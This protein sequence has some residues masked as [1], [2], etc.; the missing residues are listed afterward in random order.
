M[1]RLREL[2]GY[3]L[4][5]KANLAVN[6]ICNILNAFLS[7]F[8][9]LS[10]V[11][12][13]RIL[14]GG[15]SADVAVE[16][17]ADAAGIER[18]SGQFDA[19]VQSVGTEAALLYIC[20]GIVG[21]TI[22]KNAVGYTALFSLATIRTGVSRDLR[23]AMYVKVLKLPMAWY[24]DARKGDAISRMTNDLME[25]EFS[26]IGTVEILFKAP[27]AILVSLGT[28]FYL[29]WELTLFSILFLP[30]SG[31]VISRIAKSL[32]YAARKGKEEL[33]GLV[34]ILEET[35]AGMA[36]VKA[37]HAEDR[38]H[39]RFDASNQRFFTL[40]RRL[41]KREYLSS[42][43]S[44][45][46]SMTVIAILLAVGGR[47]VLRG[48]GLEG[49]LF[50]GYLVVFSQIIPPARSLS[51]AVFKVQKGAAS[52]D[53]LDEV[54]QA[55][56]T[57]TEPVSPQPLRFAE[58]IQFNQVGFQYPG[59][60]TPALSDF[61]LTIPKG[62][63]VALVGASGSGK[64]T[65][66]RLLLRLYDP[67]SGSIRIDG[68]DLRE[69]AT[70]ALRRCIGFVTQDPLLFNDAVAANIALFDP[71][72][73]FARIREVAEIAH[74][75]EF[76]GRLPQ[77]MATPIGD[78]GGRL[79]GGQKQRLAIA[80]A[81]YHDPPIL[82]LDEATSAL[83]AEGERL[84]QAAIERVMEGR[85]AVVIAHRLSTVRRADRIVVLDEGRIVEAGTH[86]EL[87]VQGGHYQGMVS[88]QQLEA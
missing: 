55:E 73:D 80:R 28:L 78:G 61:D 3:V 48:D 14:F 15:T 51:D 17:P 71:A 40:M 84:V 70:G 56:V 63:T 43:V 74:A 85:T 42:P 13:L 8:T 39:S 18:L 76:I 35:L 23:N 44:E 10:V 1:K 21:V 81:L 75:M 87:M 69:V 59:A 57:V 67:E 79:S 52:L 24:S 60:E 50:I 29:S 34:S 65:V 53:R 83:D 9:F 46:V 22:L 33:G 41:Y 12:F 62:E 58:D 82:V 66:A 54:L 27:I 19:F 45:F 20:L 36:V 72:P 86:E 37:F 47:L 77:G 68:Q 38:F 2:I 16:L 7:L 4:P 11:P 25:V 88:L 26:I 32:K 64:T 31:Y 49:E 6:I 30:L 5:Y